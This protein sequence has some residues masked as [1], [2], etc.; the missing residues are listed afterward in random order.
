MA[1]PVRYWRRSPL[2]HGPVSL[3]PRPQPGG[4][5]FS[6]SGS[7]DSRVTQR[8]YVNS[9]ASV[10]AYRAIPGFGLLSAEA[11]RAFAAELLGESK[12]FRV[13]TW[14][15]GNT[16]RQ[17]AGSMARLPFFLAAPCGFLAPGGRWLRLGLVALVLAV[18]RV[19]V[20]GT[21][22]HAG[23][24]IP[25]LGAGYWPLV[26]LRGWVASSRASS[27]SVASI[28]GGSAVWPLR[29]RRRACMVTCGSCSGRPA[30][31]RAHTSPDPNAYKLL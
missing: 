17:E 22:G 29:V 3:G 1:E 31:A 23:E 9:G 4:C 28:A 11:Q 8:P 7:A 6:P 21:G 14:L 5:Q 16:G 27:P 18:R 25:A 26:R 24:R 15:L 10:L 20:L 13:K 2:M 19:V 30:P 12:A